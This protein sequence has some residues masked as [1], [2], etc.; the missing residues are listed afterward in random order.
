M[1]F[2]FL[3]LNG[4]GLYIFFYLKT[5]DILNPFSL[6]LIIWFTVSGLA[7]IHLSNLQT[8]WNLE[9][10][11]V[12]CLSG[13][14]IALVGIVKT[15]GKQNNFWYNQK[16]FNINVVYKALTKLIFFC[17]L[18]CAFLEWREQNYLLP[19]LLSNQFIGD[20]KDLVVALKGIHYGAY[21]L[22]YCSVFSFFELIYDENKRVKENIYNIFVILIGIFYS[23][24]V[25]ISR[26]TLLDMAIAFLL[27][28][29]SK[30]KIKPKML[31]ILLI[32]LLT[33]FVIISQMRLNEGSLVF[34][35]ISQNSTF[36]SI[37]T[38]LTFGYQN[39]LQ[40]I[41]KGSPYT[42]VI[43]TFK[44][45]LYFWN[46]NIENYFINYTLMFFNSKT[47]LY[48]FY[49]DLGL[50]GIIVYPM[51]IFSFIG[52]IYKKA[53]E[54][55]SY[56]LLLALLQKAIYMSFFGNY[57]TGEFIIMWPY[58]ITVVLI[59]VLQKNVEK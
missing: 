18:Y 31:I 36:S 17:A 5:K 52:V 6:F 30:Y 8:K 33:G 10:Y 11:A 56:I 3:L 41:N 15:S 23:Y 34:N 24:A 42:L 29:H 44:P 21:L 4:V 55:P 12:V 20:A 50:I 39:L 16:S 54:Y 37:Y 58:I 47:F 57:F 32:V 22:P 53:K 46:L 7:C 14:S 40:L 25:I 35:A 43:Y 38:Y 19:G 59:W 13:Y 48:G 28:Y 51:L 49:H 45:I 2:V 26:G 9:M 27:I 1:S